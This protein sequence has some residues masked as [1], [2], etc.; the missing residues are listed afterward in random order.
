MKIWDCETFKD[1]HVT[2]A[3]VDVAKNYLAEGEIKEL[4]RLTVILLDIFE[5]QADLGKINTMAEVESLLDN[6]LR[7]LSR[8]VL[9]GAGLSKLRRP[10]LMH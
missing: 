8:K 1:D 7:S 10:R 3:D 9:R 2:Q 6:Q 4:N 5:D